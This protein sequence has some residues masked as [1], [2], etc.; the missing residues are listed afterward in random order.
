MLSR[1][2]QLPRGMRIPGGRSLAGYS[3]PLSSIFPLSISSSG[4]YLQTVN[5]TPFLVVGDSPWSL[6]VNCTDT[7]IDT[8]INDRSGKGLTAI[9]VEAVERAYSSQTPIYRNASGNDPFTVM[10]PVNWVISGAYWARVDYIVNKCRDLGIAVFIAPAYT[11]YGPGV[12]GWAADYGSASDATMQA[13][14]AALATRYTQGNVVWVMGGDSAGD[15]NEPANVAYNTATVPSRT[16]QWQIVL[17]IRSVRTTDIITG[18]TAR[19][20]APGGANGESYLGW[21]GGTWTGWNLNNVYGHDNNDDAPALAATAYARAGP[22]P[23]FLIEAG[24]QDTNLTDLS[25]VHP[26]IQTVLGGG[27]GGFFGGHDALWHMG[28]VA[29]DNTGAAAVL[30]T[31]LAGSWTGSSNLGNLL[32]S[33]AWH[34][35]QPKTDASLVTTALG[36]GAA[37]V[38]PA[39]A[40]DGTF[41]L[42]WTPTV[43]LTVNM[44]AFT[45]SSVRCRWWDYSNNSFA[46]IGTFANT[47]TQS[48][49]PPG[50]RLLVMDAP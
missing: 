48:F 30:S 7:Q 4:R 24:Y 38:C 31:Y 37:T 19:N 46:A 36:T 47:G 39:R 16:K 41:A 44:T 13:Y 17:G 28:S 11:G 26:A 6:P 45:I 2:M 5:A 40:S 49:T 33:Y 21:G 27:L 29:P 35:L 34:L 12:D 23:F 22:L 10:S 43:N 14:G 42:I 1:M 3:V 50:A 20:G 32:R 25:M 8:Y 18:H 9:M 15:T